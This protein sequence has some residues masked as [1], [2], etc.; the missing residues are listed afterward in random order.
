MKVPEDIPYKWQIEEAIRN[1][2][3][4]RCLSQLMQIANNN[5][6]IIKESLENNTDLKGLTWEGDGIIGYEEIDDTDGKLDRLT[7]DAYE[8]YKKI[9]RVERWAKSE[10]I[11]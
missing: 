11:L 2:N 1:N 8:S 5:E 9:K 10:K 7:R 3:L 6:R 4:K